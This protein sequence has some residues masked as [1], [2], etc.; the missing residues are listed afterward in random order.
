MHLC[1]PHLISRILEAAN[2]DPENASGRNAKDTPATKPLLIK[3][4]NG[5]DR[6]LPWNYRSAIGMLNYLSG[7]TRPDIAMAAHQTA[8]FC[9]DPNCSHEKAVMRIARYLKCMAKFGIFYKIN[10]SRGLEVFVYADFA[11]SWTKETAVG[12]NSASSRSGFVIFLFGCPLFWHSK[13]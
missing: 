6:E 10:L 13:L 12:P 5:E 3:D 2:L 11:G 4:T 7:S 9:I 8:W 1:Q